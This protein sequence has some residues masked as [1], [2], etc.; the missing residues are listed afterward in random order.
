[1]A[2]LQLSRITHRKGYTE[3]LPQLAGAELG[4][5][6][7]E[8]RLFI[9]NGKIED[10]APVVGNTEILTEFS[11]LLALSSTYTYKG[12]D[13][14]YVVQTGEGN[15]DIV[16]SLQSKFDEYVSVKDFGAVGD[17][18]TDDTDA[19]N[20]AMYELFCDDIDRPKIN[21]NARARRAL[22]FPAGTYRVTD[23]I[24][25]PPYA[26]IIGE[27]LNSSI[28]KYYSP[29]GTT[30]A[31]YVV[32]T[33]DSLFQ[34]GANLGNNNAVTP[35][36]LEVSSL[37]VTSTEKNSILLVNGLTNS[38][39]VFMDLVGGARDHADLTNNLL[40]TSIIHIIGTSVLVPND[41]TFNK[42]LTSGATYGLKINNDCRGIQFENGKMTLHYQGVNLDRTGTTTGPTGVSII[43]NIFDDIASSGIFIGDVITNSTA[44]N[45]F[46][47]VGNLFGTTPASPII[48][49]HNGTNISIGD[50]FQ[51]TDE[52]S[53]D[54][55][56]I[57]LNGTSSIAFDSTSA[58]FL[59]NYERQ[60]GLESI[61]PSG[62]PATEVFTLL[63]VNSEPQAFNI[64]Y[65]INRGPDIR[66]GRVMITNDLTTNLGNIYFDEEYTESDTIGTITLSA[67]LSLDSFNNPNG[68]VIKITPD[69]T[70]GLGNDVV[71]KYSITR[72]N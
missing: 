57:E 63:S 53:L 54:T 45:I 30:V 14:G 70:G 55:P 13:A 10:G 65:S 39:F 49:I 9:G 1:M 72:L 8:R 66:T 33:V 38:S 51:R 41:I 4:W 16:R 42:C 26:K 6:L 11:D 7:D 21:V 34:S 69:A 35:T 61:V 24:K 27:G 68:T 18:Y 44:F 56:R 15:E 2:I 64:D 31:D 62:N 23:T 5:A 59:G 28:I 19:I 47:N 3:N 58:V 25:I 46:Y 67:E 50:L 37:G 48:D 43:R 36:G 12:T 40:D 29:D 32:E 17:D 52:E 71:F 60:V 22:H 20:R